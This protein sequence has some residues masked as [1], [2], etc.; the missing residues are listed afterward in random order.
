M[1]EEILH[2]QNAK[3]LR[4]VCR[5]WLPRDQARGIALIAHGLGEHSGRYQHVAAAL[6]E[7]GFACYG[8]DHYGHGLSDG[9]RAYVPDAWQAVDDL[10]LLHDMARERHPHTPSLLLGHS[11]GALISLGYALRC[12]ERLR[13]MT[14]IGAP[15]HSEFDKPRWLIALCLR[16]APHIPRLRLS[17]P[18]LPSWL[19]HDRAQM[20]AWRADP[21]VDKGMWRVGTSAEL[22]RFSRQIRARVGEL[23][24]PLQILHG[25]DDHLAPASGSQFLARQASSDDIT[26]RIYPELRHELVN[27]VGG[28][29][30]I[31]RIRDWLLERAYASN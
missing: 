24:L 29:A 7:A 3:D 10:A 2:F 19:T 31:A 13:G 20:Q 22:I 27:E 11:M 25:A 17:P 23:R 4:I 8:I 30:I 21:L 18:A 9:A 16:A 15:L 5:V 28:E 6:T 26:L 1:I 14:L 12:P